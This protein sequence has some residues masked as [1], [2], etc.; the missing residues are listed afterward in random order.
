MVNFCI[1]TLNVKN[2]I[3]LQLTTEHWQTQH[4]LALMKK[5][6]IFSF[7]LTWRSTAKQVKLLPSFAY[8][9]Q[10]EGYSISFYIKTVRVKN[11]NSL[12]LAAENWLFRALKT[13]SSP[14]LSL[15]GNDATAKFCIPRRRG[16]I[17]GQFL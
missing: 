8:N 6:S 9:C 11:H 17:A 12:H 5:S 7:L 13:K 3:F 4:F 1:E 16:R 2:Y 14:L 10:E 15:L